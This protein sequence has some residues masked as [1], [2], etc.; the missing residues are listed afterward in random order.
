M[1]PWVDLADYTSPSW[2]ADRG[3]GRDFIPERMARKFAANYAGSPLDPTASAINCTVAGFPPVLVESGAD[4]AFCSQVAAYVVKLRAAG[5]NCRHTE[6]P[7]AVHVASMFFGTK[8]AVST[9]SW[10][11][12]I[13]FVEEIW[14]VGEGCTA[15]Q[16][17]DDGGDGAGAL[18][19]EDE[20]I[21]PSLGVL[22]G[23]DTMH[24]VSDV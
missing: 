10:E 14:G 6:T 18:L 13:S 15:H 2:G 16:G 17:V 4:E 12:V 5:V 3:G 24:S 1:S 20:E 9:Q 8:A 22:G 11:R 21:G 23:A 7:G 19:S